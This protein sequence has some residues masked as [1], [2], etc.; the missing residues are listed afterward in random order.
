MLDGLRGLYQDLSALSRD[1]LPNVDRLVHELE[2]TIGDFKKLL[3]KEPKKNESRQAILSGKIPIL[4]CVF[5]SSNISFLGKITLD[6]A[7][8]SLNDAFQQDV[9]QVADALDIDEVQ[10]AEYLM[11]AQQD[12]MKLDRSPVL[13]AIIRF[14]ERR[15]FLLECLR[16][17]LCE[18]FE[19]EREGI[20]ALM[21]DVVAMI[22]DIQNGP[23]R[24]GS[25]YAR[26]CMD[27]M[28]DIEKWLVLLGEQIQKASIVGQTHSSDVMEVIEYQRQ[29]LGK[30]HESLGAIISYLFKGTF[31]SSEDFRKLLER[32]KKIERLDMLLVHYLPALIFA[33]ALFGS[34]EGQVRL[35]EARSL[36]LAIAGNKESTNWTLPKLHAAV[37][38]LWLAEYAGWYFDC[39]PQSELQS[40]NPAEELA[41]LTQMFMGALD[42]GGLEFILSVC[43]GTAVEEWAMPA[44]DEIVSLLLKDAPSLNVEPDPLSPYFRNLLK[45]GLEAF[46]ESLIANI[47]DAIR[48]LKS[49]EDMQRLDQMTAL[50]EASN[51]SLQRGLVEPR[52]HLETLLLVIAFAFENRHDAAQDFWAD[53]DGNLYGFLQWVSKRQTVP[54]V[55]AFCEMLC[56][57]SGGEENSASAHRFLL[58]ED[59]SSPKFRRSASMNWDQMFAEL[60]LYATRVTERPSAAQPSIL[61][62][63]KPETVDADEPE[64]PVM[65]TSYLRL[66]SHLCKENG[67]VRQ[68]VLEHPTASLPNT[69]LTLCAA[70][71]PHH[72]RAVIFVTLRCLMINRTTTHG[73]EM[74]T[75]IDQWISG[76]GPSSFSLSKAPSLVQ[77]PVLNERQAFD[78]I[79]ESFD[80]TNAFVELL[81]VLSSPTM[82]SADSEMSLPFPESLGSS[83]RM[84]G[85]EPYVDFVMG[86]ALANKSVLLD[87]KESRVLQLNCLDFAITGLESFNENL[88]T[89]VNQTVITA[90]TNIGNIPFASYLRLHPFSRIME[91]LFN[92]D[93]L[94]AVFACAH[95]NIEEVA[96]VSSESVLVCSLIRTIQLMNLILEHQPTFFDIVRPF[97]RSL[98]RQGS[99]TMASASLASFEDGVMDNLNLISNLCLYCG[100]GHPEL[101]LVSLALLEKLSASRKL[102]KP[103]STFSQ[104]QTSNQIVELLN[105]NVEADRI[106][107]SL[108]SQMISDV[109]ELENGPAAS[110]Y[111]IKL[112]LVRL[113]DRCLKMVPDKPALA[114]VLLG[115]R[116]VGN[117]LDV[118]QGGLFE[119]S[120]SLL[121]AI[122]EFVKSYPHGS[123]G[124]IDSWMIHLK[125]LAFQVLQYLWTSPLSSSLVLPELR[126]SQLLANIFISQQIIGPDSLWDGNRMTEP[127]FWFS[128]SAVALSDF[129]LYRS[130]VLDYATTEVRA[131]FR[132]TPPSFQ[133]DILSTLFGN[134][135]S[136]DDSI[137]S[138]PSVFDLFDFA[139][140]DVEW[141]YAFP[142]LRFFRDVDV[143]MCATSQ[144]SGFPTLYD[145]ASVQSLLQ[146]AKEHLLV[147]GQASVQD[148]EQV[149]SEQEKL[150][151][152]LRATNRSRQIRHY[153][154]LT[155]KAWVELII[156]IIVTCHID[157]TRMATFLLHTL[158]TVLPKL[159]N[160]IA[161]DT[162]EAAELARLAEILIEKLDSVSTSAN[163]DIVDER[164]HHLFQTCIRGIPSVLEETVLRETFYHI[165]SR[166]LTRITQKCDPKARFGVRAQ[167]VINSSG[168]SL[169]DTICDDAYSGDESC[170]VSALVFLNL[171]SVLGEQQSSPILV[172]LIS[173]SNYLSLFLDA[174]RSMASEFQKVQGPGMWSKKRFVYDC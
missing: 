39:G 99:S 153:R 66:I 169:I 112:G 131:A 149:S 127:D 161:G 121:H 105:T 60:H 79:L 139:D 125:R 50:R 19:V 14:H 88:I 56:S 47:P 144:E 84:P 76:L 34:S 13:V 133:R 48:Q 156:T 104:W 68:W 36:H 100:T 10:A 82:D 46:T 49:E 2:A 108:A 111:L 157:P 158:Q 140:I 115:F 173:Q 123:E 31:T 12:S 94:R 93:V 81:T 135:P 142:D 64:S 107:R 124:I 1:S 9:L 80:Q 16:L 23:L 130:L 61:R 163:E 51:T 53:T 168:S 57:L 92:E 17:I 7:E 132:N 45:E 44:R 162:A 141:A 120:S 29:S 154:L 143:S 122:I 151:L 28:G 155:L 35:Q 164:L 6:G 129:L 73:N 136:E 30:Q 137:I 69:L 52:M 25:L 118:V 75:L 96:R 146:L 21:Q 58:D 106:S 27:S 152:F 20:R 89:L 72:L 167:K 55:S 85:I 113:L 4:H 74:W 37:V 117:A 78:R 24:N 91:W 87:G 11:R 59:N 98:P 148:E 83:Y 95:Q 101:T 170:R 42:D 33:I 43:A 22:L 103:T 116:C 172:A 8:F 86:Q 171:L 26:K 40:M 71:I 114:H 110:G 159:E 32:V 166:Y 63:R 62:S 119:N 54:R 70:P 97:I 150:I 15:A 102:N 134:S 38:V 128:E 65:L 5:N 67:G 160:S 77:S 18:S 165:C 41:S 138:H 147:T 126:A 3:D 145:L 174:V 90:N 109:R